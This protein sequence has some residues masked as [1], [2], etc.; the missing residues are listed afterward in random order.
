MKMTRRRRS[1]G[2]GGFTILRF[3]ALGGDLGGKDFCE[4]VWTLEGHQGELFTWRD[5]VP[6]HAFVLICVGIL[7]LTT[8]GGGTGMEEIRES[9]HKGSVGSIV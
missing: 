3:G 4:R 2:V 7:V 1:D 5:S 8:M 6:F 9:V